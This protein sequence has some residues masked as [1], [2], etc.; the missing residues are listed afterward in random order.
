MSTTRL[1]HFDKKMGF[2]LGAAFTDDSLLGSAEPLFNILSGN[3]AARNRWIAQTTNNIFP[4]GGMRNELG[5]NLFGMLRDVENDDIGEIIRNRNNWLDVFDRDGA[6]PTLTD[7]VT[8]EEIKTAEGSLIGRIWGQSGPGPKVSSSPSELGQFL[9]DIEF[10]SEPTFATS[11]K[12]VPLTTN[13][14]Q[15]LANL[16]G[17]DGRFNKALIKIKKKADNLTYKTPEGKIIKGYVN[18]MRHAR[19][20]GL[21]GETLDD[22]ENIKFEIKRQLYITKNELELQLSTKDDIQ[23][24]YEEKYIIKK[25]S[26]KGNLDRIIE[27]AN[28]QS[29]N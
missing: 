22:Y 6:L 4:L 3:S 2:I 8:G 25:Q 10:D 29:S 9:I 21:T 23:K 15:E 11:R 16:I 5:K 28:P 14:I 19:R 20:E 27:L 26:E 17:Q 1:E 18:I 7:Y 13:E 12:G 24:R